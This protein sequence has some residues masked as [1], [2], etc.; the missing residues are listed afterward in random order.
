MWHPGFYERN[1]TDQAWADVPPQAQGKA[2]T[3][4]GAY[5]TFLDSPYCHVQLGTLPISAFNGWLLRMDKPRMR[6][7]SACYRYRFAAQLREYILK[8]SLSDSEAWARQLPTRN[9][10]RNLMGVFISYRR[11]DASSAAGRLYDRLAQHFGAEAVFIDIDTIA[12][13][14]DFE[15]VITTTLQSCQTMLVVVGRRWLNVKG[16]DGMRR[17]DDPSDFVRMEIRAA[18]AA[19]SQVIPVLVEGANMPR[20]DELP[21]DLEAFARHQAFELSDTRFHQDVD[22]LLRFVQPTSPFQHA[23]K[24]RISQEDWRRTRSGSPPEHLDPVTLSDQED[25]DSVIGLGELKAWLRRRRQFFDPRTALL[26]LPYPKGILVFGGLGCGKGLLVRATANDWSLPL[27][28]LNLA[29]VFSPYL[30]E[31]ELG[32]REAI[33]QAEESAP[34]ILWIDEFE[35]LAGAR[36]QRSSS[37]VWRRILS[38]LLIWMVENDS[39]VFVFA[40]ASDFDSLPSEVIRR[41][42]AVFFIDLPTYEDRLEL[43]RLHLAKRKQDCSGLDLEKQAAATEGFSN[44]EIVKIVNSAIYEWLQEGDPNAPLRDSHIQAAI[45]Q[46]VPATESDPIFQRLRSRATEG[47]I[48]SASRSAEDST[49][50]SI[51]T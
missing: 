13:G 39:R 18:L 44:G 22:R 6:E 23:P 8:G 38:R 49:E 28:K 17:L 35:A 19:A 14:D 25:F 11:S 45:G 24:E 7:P 20:P 31:S 30:G 37:S 29:S 21:T 46:L 2:Y 50:R 40:T 36:D 3:S 27:Y 32:I 10:T 15:H 26:G 33:K 4:V 9:E 42:D 41:W 34:C 5:V 43:I 48:R 51:E 47:R 12:P 16:T 1:S